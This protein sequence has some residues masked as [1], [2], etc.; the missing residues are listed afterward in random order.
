MKKNSVAYII[1]IF[2]VLAL[3]FVGVTL[4]KNSQISVEN[5]EAIINIDEN[6]DMNVSETWVVNWPAGGTVSFRDIGYR[7]YHEYN[8]LRQ[9]PK[10]VAFFNTEDI[11]V[12]VFGANGDKINESKYRVGYSF[13]G[14]KDE[15]GK[16]IECYPDRADCESI[17]IHVYNGMQSQMTFKYNYKIE[18]AVTKYMDT[19][20]LN[21]RLLEYFE[22]GI[23]DASVVIN[24]P[25]TSKDNINAWG[26]GLSDGAVIIE[27]S[28]VTLDIDKIK[29][30]EFLEFR[31][32][33]PKNLVNVDDINEL[34][35]AAYNEIMNYQQKLAYETNRRILIANIIFYG[36]FVVAI[37]T[38]Y[39]AYYIYKKYDKEHKASF[40]GNYYRELPADYSPAEMSYLY[41]FKNINNEDLTATLLDLIR[42]KY[43]E[44]DNVDSFINDKNPNFIIRKNRDKIGGLLRHEKHLIDWFIDEI[45]NGKE[46]S[47]RQIE[48]YGKK[49]YQK[50]KSF[51]DNAATF[52]SY[53]KQEGRKHDFF[54]NVKKGRAYVVIL[55]PFIYA[56]VASCTQFTFNISNTFAIFASIALTIGLLIY[57]SNIKRRSKNGNEDYVK[58]KAFKN[59]LE[60]FGNMKD[61][62]IP[63]IVVWEHYLVYATS[64][65]VADKVM[66]QLEVRLPNIDKAEV[67]NQST[68]IGFGYRYYRFNLG[69]TLG[70]INT[71]VATARRSSVQTITAHNAA[72]ISG[73]GRG[74]GFGGG[75]SFGGGGGGFRGR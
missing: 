3:F 23:K 66:E 73:G 55:I 29:N 41:Y 4:I 13:N 35:F 51:Q 43:L 60:D 67:F 47:I 16:P 58:W 36:T 31:I 24:L 72:R 46:V 19:A 26:H 44:L 12:E 14:Q 54:D 38:L 74:G 22:S 45:G 27:D 6:G 17:F 10:N 57:I 71:S 21:W 52:V 5:F 30:G 2:I 25:T 1:P 56:I 9:D 40:D 34:D 11:S 62:P 18:G 63:G 69:Y 59:F 61:Y 53:A 64:L 65:K 28:K 42:R 75:S 33:F 37:I 50:A 32:L 49:D 8:E 39:G 7:K 15:L 70:R 68:F 48:N 20:E